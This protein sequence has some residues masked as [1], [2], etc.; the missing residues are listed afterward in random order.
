MPPTQTTLVFLQKDDNV[1]LGLKKRDFGVGYWNGVGGKLQAGES[2]VEAAVRETTEELNI[3]IMPQDLIHAGELE[4]HYPGR[5]EDDLMRHVLA[6][7]FITREWRDNPLESDEVKPEWFKIDKLPFEQM[8]A[9][10]PYWL[11][12]VLDG[13]TV[14]AIFTFNNDNIT[15]AEANVEVL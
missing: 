10:D 4:F 2:A 15:I 13:K 11:P 3:I 1:L 5:S 14:K 7:V 6:H 9:D 8:W 12:H